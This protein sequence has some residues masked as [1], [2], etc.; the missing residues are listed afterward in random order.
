MKVQVLEHGKWTCEPCDHDKL[1]KG[2]RLED[3]WC[4]VSFPFLLKL[5][6]WFGTQQIEVISELESSYSYD[7]SIV[8]SI[9]IYG[10]TKNLPVE[11]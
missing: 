5:S 4:G 3:S 2:F 11:D 10:A 1:G 7:D 9:E 6:E 8:V